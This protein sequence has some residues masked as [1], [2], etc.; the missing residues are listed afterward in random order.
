MPVLLNGQ[1]QKHPQKAKRGER[2]KKQ[3][4][5]R[6]PLKGQNYP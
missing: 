5:E 6:L 2:Q 3:R 1:I 4:G